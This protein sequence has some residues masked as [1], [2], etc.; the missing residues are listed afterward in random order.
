MAVAHEP[1]M[2]AIARIRTAEG[3]P[4][5]VRR[6]PHRGLVLVTGH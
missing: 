5:S 2:E 6:L 1:I 4:T 3:A